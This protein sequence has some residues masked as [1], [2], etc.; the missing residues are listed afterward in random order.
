[1]NFESEGSLS[2]WIGNFEEE[3]DLFDYVDFKYDEDGNSSCRFAIDAG[4]AWFDHDFQE[5]HYTEAG[6]SDAKRALAGRSF[7]ASFIEAAALAIA[8]TRTPQDNAV[9][10]LYDMAYDPA[11][12]NMLWES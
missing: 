11:G 5:A 2:L 7:S 8:S 9:F 12:R 6:L 1:M 4:L 3:E 10:I